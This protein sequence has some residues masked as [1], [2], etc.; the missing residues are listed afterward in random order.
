[1]Q[2]TL[3]EQMEMRE[4]TW[5]QCI[6]TMYREANRLRREASLENRKYR[7]YL[8]GK[9]NPRRSLIILQQPLQAAV[10]R[11]IPASDHFLEKLIRHFSR[12]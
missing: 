2:Y 5:R 7:D 12:Q 3:S 10:G 1:M 9:Y 8:R 4:Y 6:H 11:T